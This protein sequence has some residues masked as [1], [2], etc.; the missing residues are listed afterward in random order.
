MKVLFITA[1]PFLPQMLGGA[2]QSGNAIITGLRARGHK[3]AVLCALMP[4]GVLGFVDRVRLKLFRS[5]AVRDDVCGYPVYRAWFPWEATREVVQKFKP[6][7]IIVL[8]REPVRMALSVQDMG[9]PIVMKLQDV[10]FSQH[11]GDFTE[12]GDIP[13]IANSTFTAQTYHD[14]YGVN[15]IVIHPIICPDR[16]KTNTTREEVVFINPHP[17]K[18]LDIALQVAQACPDIPFC[19]VESW[20]L[21]APE[22][23]SL[24]ERIAPLA[25]VRLQRSVQD[26][27]SVYSKAKIVLAPSVW[28][29]AFGRVASE[30]QCSGIPVVA[31]NQGGLPEAVGPGG[32]LLDPA[33][34]I[35][36]WT[37]AIRKLWDD[38]IYYQSMC[39]AAFAHAARPEIDPVEHL[40]QL[41]K[42]LNA[43]IAKNGK[44]P[45]A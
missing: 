34:D 17:K 21:S 28:R 36:A 39:D 2:Q 29:E 45:G 3:A 16:Y 33:G 15:P 30:A 32:I 24:R 22:L 26:M 12:L 5:K 41:E 11:G 42:I 4:N 23:A 38:P 20:P 8:A 37:G 43:L 19:F 18:G 44:G 25:N 31:S 10:E 9:I 40:V 1:H 27:K 35:S 14:A 6:D 7:V 13:C